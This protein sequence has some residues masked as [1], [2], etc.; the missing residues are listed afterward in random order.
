MAGQWHSISLSRLLAEL[1]TD[2][3]V[4]LSQREAAKRL[5]RGGPN[6]LISAP[7]VS[8]WSI[9]IN[10]FQ[11]FMVLVLLGSVVVSAFLGEFMDAA[12]IMAIVFLNAVLGFVQEYRAERALDALRKLT[13][14]HCRVLRDGRKTMIDAADL[15]PG[16]IIYLE[17]GDR[18]PADARLLESQLLAVDESNLTGESIPVS[19]DEAWRGSPDASLG[20]RRNTVFK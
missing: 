17:P 7:P 4:G 19:K 20:D 6:L 1:K 16:D 14:P 15:V 3:K 18:V 8:A 9:F 10:Q 11:D 2:E 5:T 13:A 12:A